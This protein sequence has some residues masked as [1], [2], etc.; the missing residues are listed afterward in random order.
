MSMYVNLRG[1]LICS[2]LRIQIKTINLQ[3]ISILTGPSKKLASGQHNKSLAV[4]PPGPPSTLSQPRRWTTVKYNRLHR[5]QAFRWV[6]PPQQ[7]GEGGRRFPQLPPCR[8]TWTGCILPQRTL[9]FKADALSDLCL[10]GFRNSFLPC[11]FRPRDS[12]SSQSP[13]LSTPL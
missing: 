9:A 8:V 2:P 5:P 6:H 11:P 3:C 12:N 1:G 4:C 13:A 7:W 10:P